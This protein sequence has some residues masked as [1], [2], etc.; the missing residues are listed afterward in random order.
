MFLSEWIKTLK[1]IYDLIIHRYIV[2]F[3]AKYFII[4][5]CQDLPSRAS[6][7]NYS[8]ILIAI[9]VALLLQV[10][11]LLDKVLYKFNSNKRAPTDI[12]TSSIVPENWAY[13]EDRLSFILDHNL[14]HIIT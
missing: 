14:K 4:S 5:C 11:F 10:G 1:S 3:T 13:V 8:N 6:Q 9:C 2:Y 7:T 12:N